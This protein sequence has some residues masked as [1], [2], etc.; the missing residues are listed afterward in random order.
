MRDIKERGGGDERTKKKVKIG[1][2]K[3]IQKPYKE[4]SLTLGD[5]KDV[6]GGRSEK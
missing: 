1:K 3:E 6:V 5:G 4:M 2:S